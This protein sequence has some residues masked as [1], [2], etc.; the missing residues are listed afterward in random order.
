VT[1]AGGCGDEAVSSSLGDRWPMG[2]S[3]RGDG[4][5]ARSRTPTT[6][7]TVA[8]ATTEM[9]TLAKGDEERPQHPSQPGCAGGGWGG[10]LLPV[11]RRTSSWR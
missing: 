1:G 6:T 3:H 10:G 2:R 7:V 4:H 8:T 11:V 9:V 5:L